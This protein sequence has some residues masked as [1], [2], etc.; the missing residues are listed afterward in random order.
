MNNATAE[1]IA[2]FIASHVRQIVLDSGAATVEQADEI[3]AER[4]QI[5]TTAKKSPMRISGGGKVS[6]RQAAIDLIVL[7]V[8][9]TGKFG[10]ASIRAVSAG[11]IGHA[12]MQEAGRIGMRHRETCSSTTCECKSDA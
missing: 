8:A 11:R 10:A 6:K 1:Q 4:R 9:R 7:D 2:K 12:T 3:L 5:P